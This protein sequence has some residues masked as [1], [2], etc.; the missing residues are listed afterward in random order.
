MAS[1]IRTRAPIVSLSG[2]GVLLQQQTITP[3]DDFISPSDGQT[4]IF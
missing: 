4:T 1:E 3:P 2:A